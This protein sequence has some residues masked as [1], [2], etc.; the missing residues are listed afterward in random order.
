[1]TQTIVC[2][3]FWSKCSPKEIL[4]IEKRETVTH[5][6][7]DIEIGGKNKEEVKDKKT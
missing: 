2:L 6:D 7:R 1:M 4:G 5:R 3:S